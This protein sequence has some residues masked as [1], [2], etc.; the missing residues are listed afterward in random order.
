MT[1][2]APEPAPTDAQR[3][4]GSPGPG[5]TL[6]VSAPPSRRPGEP[7]RAPRRPGPVRRVTVGSARALPVPVAGRPSRPADDETTTHAPPPDPTQLCCSVVRAAVEVLRDERPASQVARW[8]TPTVLEQLLERARLVRGARTGPARVSRPVTVRRVR[9][10]RLSPSTAEATVVL[11]D[12][13]RVRAAAVRLEAH[14]G[15]WR[16]AVLEIG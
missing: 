6:R 12:D 15:T 5:R 8:V 13:G 2:T 10:V 11:D 14:R 1:T 7:P 4:A 16:V 9:V 3:P